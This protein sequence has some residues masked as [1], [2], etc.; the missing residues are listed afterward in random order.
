[1]NRCLSLFV[2]VGI[3]GLMALSLPACSSLDDAPNNTE[4]L[5]RVEDKRAAEPLPYRLAVA[6]VAHGRMVATAEEAQSAETQGAEGQTPSATSGEGE[7]TPDASETQ[8]GAW[9]GH[10]AHDDLVVYYR[11]PLHRNLL[12]APRDDIDPAAAPNDNQGAPQHTADGRPV[13]WRCARCQNA[14]GAGDTS[15]AWC[16]L[17]F[18]PATESPEGPLNASDPAVAQPEAGADEQVVSTQEPQVVSERFICY[19]CEAQIQPTD[20]VCPNCQTA[21]LV[22]P[23]YESLLAT[24][25]GNEQEL[26]GLGI[27][28]MRRTSKRRVTFKPDP[29]KMQEDFE[30]L[31]GGYGL[32]TEV[33][34]VDDQELAGDT[35]AL[36]EWA[37]DRYYDYLLVPRLRKN[38]VSYV[39]INGAWWGSLVLWAGAWVPSLWVAGE[40]YES[41]VEMELELYHV[42]SRKPVPGWEARFRADHADDVDQFDRRIN[43]ATLGW[44]FLFVPMGATSPTDDGWLN[45]NKRI[46]PHSYA[47]I[48]QDVIERGFYQTFVANRIPYIVP[49]DRQNVAF[50]CGV[51]NVKSATSGDLRYV[52]NDVDQLA[53]SF[54]TVTG[55]KE[56]E[57]RDPQAGQDR[58]RT[59]V[60]FPDE[61]NPEQTP[62]TANL[63][64]WLTEDLQRFGPNDR[65]VLYFAGFG[66]TVESPNAHYAD[67]YEKYYVTV[68]TDPTRIAETALPVFEIAQAVRKCNSR[69][70]VVVFDCSFARSAEDESIGRARTLQVGAL[71]DVVLDDDQLDNEF[72]KQFSER[73]GN[74]RGVVFAS[75]GIKEVAYE[76]E[77]TQPEEHGLLTATM[78]EGVEGQADVEAGNG[79]GKVDL[80]ELETFIRQRFRAFSAASGLQM[81][82]RSFGNTR[83]V[84]IVLNGGKLGSEVAPPDEDDTTPAAE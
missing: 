28:S 26:A 47:Q 35:E 41:S 53:K 82:F 55:W 30:A 3:V 71:P 9:L 80:D 16:G 1:M 4:I 10:P 66:A 52:Y 83:K 65:I 69:N 56:G 59:L 2:T 11:K 78:L 22:E 14:V 7:G 18:A 29:V 75:A 54:R 19:F 39:S 74:K 42:R 57:E 61:Q 12:F 15:C 73:G 40:E 13:E 20:L 27:G 45:L 81:E 84:R 36:L 72:L 48:K 79:D 58:S 51:P 60:Y 76:S 49:S 62:T 34:S 23:G 46:T 8:E 17:A 31:L 63:R 5:K 44:D 50:I 37:A 68:D 32:F 6:P 70:V 25:D 21:L 64:K 43:Y 67:G 38:E 33:S 24:T 77:F